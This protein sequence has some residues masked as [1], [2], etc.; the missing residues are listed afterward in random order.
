M[1]LLAFAAT[2][3]RNSINRAL[4]EYAA[5]RL[6]SSFQPDADIEIID[7]NDY[8]MPIY[9]IDREQETGIPAAARDLF[10]KIGAADG[11][12]VSF[13]EHNGLVTAAWKNAFDWMSRID[14]KVWQDKPMVM[15]AASPGPRA[16]ANV[17]ASQ[18][19]LTPFFGGE[20]RGTLGIG[21]WSEAWDAANSTL[22]R[23]EDSAALDETLVKL[24]A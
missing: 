9:S 17:L 15:L 11:I 13:A 7:L 14:G 4:V 1:K 5:N 20:I 24:A 8:E 16:G 18:E 10:A 6:K 2:N 19:M 22:L 3:S 12:I 23:A 21:T